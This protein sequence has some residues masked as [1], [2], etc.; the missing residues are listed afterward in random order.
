MMAGGVVIVAVMLAPIDRQARSIAVSIALA[1][2]VISPIAYS[3]WLWR[4]NVTR[5]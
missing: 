1:V 3:W 5:A 4:R 2:M